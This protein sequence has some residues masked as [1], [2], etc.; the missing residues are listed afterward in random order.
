MLDQFEEYFLYRFREARGGRFADELAECIN[1][2]DLRAHFLISIRENAYSEL[3]D[4][5]QGRVINVYG[6][7]VHLEHLTRESARLAIEKP[8]ASY[9]LLHQLETPVEIDPDLVKVI[10]D[11]LKPGQFA[12]DQGGIGRLAGN[13]DTGHR[14]GEV[15]A[16]YL[17]LV[18]RRIWETELTRGSRTLRRETLMELGGPKTIVQNYVHRALENLPDDDRQAA[19][20]ILRYLVTPSG[21]KIALAPSDLA[22]Y[23]QRSAAEVNVLLERLTGIL[24]KVPPPSGQES[25]M[26][27]EISHDFLAPAILDWVVRR[28]AEQLEA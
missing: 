25:G 22:D 12:P 5:F 2:A 13:S 7:F 8:I 16:P 28:R 9:N 20:D 4:L 15:A 21:T 10:L 18:M 1:R 19:A 26:R 11:Q 24:R 14:D 17:Q 23:T 6:N 3:G 27:F